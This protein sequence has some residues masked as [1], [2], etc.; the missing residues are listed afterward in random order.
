MSNLLAI[1][2]RSSLPG[3][4]TMALTAVCLSLNQLT[5]LELGPRGGQDFHI[6]LNLDGPALQDAGQSLEMA[7]GALGQMMIVL[8]V[9]ATTERGPRS[10]WNAGAPGSQPRPTVANLPAGLLALSPR[11][12]AGQTLPALATPIQAAPA[13]PAN[14]PTTVTLAPSTSP[15]PATPPAD[16]APAPPQAP[17]IIGRCQN[18]LTGLSSET[19]PSSEWPV[20]AVTPCLAAGQPD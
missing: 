8:H 20:P 13:K 2:G 18:S 5:S 12:G 7:D 6:D 15:A 16:T 9:K 17:P 19:R 1:A 14:P 3:L 11:P 10:A 4:A